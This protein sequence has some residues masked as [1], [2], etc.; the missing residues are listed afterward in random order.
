MSSLTLTPTQIAHL[1]TLCDQLQAEGPPWTTPPDKLRRAHDVLMRGELEAL[2]PPGLFTVLGS[3]REDGSR[4]RYTVNDEG[5]ACANGQKGRS[6]YGCYHSV[7]A[8]LW[9]RLGAATDDDA[10]L[11]LAPTPTVEERLAAAPHAAAPAPA[12]TPTNDPETV[13]KHKEHIL[14]LLRALHLPIA[15]RAQ[16]EEGVL[17]HAGLPLVPEH[18]TAIITRLTEAVTMQQATPRP[19]VDRYT[20]NVHGKPYLQ[21]A[22][23]L[24]YA[25]ECGL[26]K[27]EAR[28]TYID[29]TFAVAEAIATF[30]DGRVFA[31]AGEATPDNV[32]PQVKPHFAR[33]ALT[34]AKARA[35]RDALNLAEA[36]AE[37]IA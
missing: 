27:L 14:H 20:I 30:A 18:Y 25:H 8:V 4:P 17:T 1:A 7:A 26:V 37:E 32:V 12:A 15:T 35:L 22:G 11:L 33:M 19:N 16:C 6:K 5:C 34:R 3:P 28:F 24:A 23:I 10:P 31:E 29:K 2:Y 36:I 21:Y 9:Q 13:R